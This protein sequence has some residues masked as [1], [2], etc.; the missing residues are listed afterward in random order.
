MSGSEIS[1]TMLHGLMLFILS[2]L[3][4]EPGAIELAKMVYL[5]DVERVRL[6]G[7][8]MTGESYTYQFK[9]PLARN[10][11]S[12]ITDM[13]GLEI[14]VTVGASRGASQHPK[15]AHGLGLNP[16]FRPSLDM[17]D[18][19]IARRVLARVRGLTP[20]EIER[21]AHD[22]EPMQ[23]ILEEERRTGE[24]RLSAPIDFSLVER[25]PLVQ[26]WRENMARPVVPDS[27]FETFLQQES[28][29]IDQI[30]ASLG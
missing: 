3:D 4:R 15:H 1:P 6:T 2:E 30:L 19:V 16:R 28:R 25:N 13:D 11:G 23:A 18:M 27:E 9:G 17:L 14:S 29:E 24:S 22:T 26:K 8:T 21:M 5:I 12:C 10:F 20:L 7:S